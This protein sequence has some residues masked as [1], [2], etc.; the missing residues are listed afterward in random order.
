MNWLARDSFGSAL[1]VAFRSE[2]EALFRLLANHPKIEIKKMGWSQMDVDWILHWEI[3]QN[4]AY[5]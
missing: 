2:N 4:V 1:H 3:C 5:I